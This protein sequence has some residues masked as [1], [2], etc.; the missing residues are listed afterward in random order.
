MLPFVS[1]FAMAQAPPSAPP[2]VYQADIS[3]DKGAAAATIFSF[4]GLMFVV[5]LCVFCERRRKR[6]LENAR[7]KHIALNVRS[8]RP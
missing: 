5:W 7:L 2:D 4:L 8:M 1:A 3:Y 6:Q